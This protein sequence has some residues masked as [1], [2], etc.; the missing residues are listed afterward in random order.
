ML[1]ATT[2]K[3]TNLGI[4]SREEIRT[5][6][7]LENPYVLYVI[8]FLSGRISKF[9]PVLMLA[10]LAALLMRTTASSNALM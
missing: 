5:I 9:Q 8:F 2:F 10:H 6:W 1:A 7:K 4:K 3:K